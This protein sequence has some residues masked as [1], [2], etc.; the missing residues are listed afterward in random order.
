MLKYNVNSEQTIQLLKNFS[1]NA[2][3]NHSKQTGFFVSLF[4][5]H[6]NSSKYGYYALDL[7]FK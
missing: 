3:I 2:I 4:K 1:I 7:F 6:K 5:K